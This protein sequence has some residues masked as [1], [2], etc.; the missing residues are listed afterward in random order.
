MEGPAVSAEGL[1]WR[2]HRT[3]SP[4]AVGPRLLI[5]QDMPDY[6]VVDFQK[7]M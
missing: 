6:F 3:R 4:T 2:R 7:Y 5:G 1:T